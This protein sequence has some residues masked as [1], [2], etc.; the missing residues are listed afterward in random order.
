[1]T[2]L[3]ANNADIYKVQLKWRDMKDN[4]IVL[5]QTSRLGSFTCYLPNSVFEL[6]T[7]SGFSYWPLKGRRVVHNHQT[8]KNT[9]LKFPRRH[10]L[11][12]KSNWITTE[13]FYLSDLDP[14]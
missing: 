12:N 3:P 6:L 1:M 5:R 9:N 14:K 4:K 7:L 8:N 13:S 2:T 10:Y 11:E